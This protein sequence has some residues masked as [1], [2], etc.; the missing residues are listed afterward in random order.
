MGNTFTLVN[1]PFLLITSNA[2]HGHSHSPSHSHVIIRIIIIPSFENRNHSA[3]DQRERL[4]HGSVAN[5]RSLIACNITTMICSK[6]F[7]SKHCEPLSNSCQILNITI[8][9][10]F[11]NVSLDSVNLMI[12]HGFQLEKII[13]LEPGICEHYQVGSQAEASSN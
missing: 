7:R 5:L 4:S 1:L 12:S 13:N 11:Q 8:H 6:P 3:L 10:Y 9:K 2:G